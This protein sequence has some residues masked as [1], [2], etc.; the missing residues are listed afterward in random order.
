MKWISLFFVSIFCI[1]VSSVYAA[2][3]NKTLAQLD[4]TRAAV[5]AATWKTEGNKEAAADL[6]RARTALKYADESHK[7]GRSMF[8]FGDISPETEKEIKL[9]VDMADLAT[10]TALSRVGFVRAVAELEAIE[11]QFA[12]ISAK[13]KLFEDRM[14]ELKRLRLG[15][16]VCRKISN[17][18][19]IIKIEK[20]ILASQ[21]DQLAAEQSR[22][23]KLKIEQLELSRKLD[24]MKAEN[25]RLSTQLGKQPTE[26]K[27]HPAV[28]APLPDDPKKK[29]PKKP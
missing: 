14:A 4:A 7:S 20:A 12:S 2:G 28:P 18:L 24:E 27:T 13:L 19:E 8:G 9:S 21:V 10:T 15:V 1:S 22:A 25:A 17:E 26:I 5:E 29:A 3:K 11:K 16:D 23:D 6:E